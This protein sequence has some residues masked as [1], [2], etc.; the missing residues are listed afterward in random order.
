M[1]E[2]RDTRSAL[3]GSPR[4]LG[5]P[6]LLAYALPAIPLAALTLPL[7]VL[8]PTFYTETLG[9]P[10]ASVGFAL[11]VVRIFDAVNDPL[12]GWAADRFRPRFGRRRALFALSLP[13]TAI[14]AFM[15][16]WPPTDASIAW[17]VGWGLMLSLGY[18]AALIPFSAWGAELATDYHGRSRITGWREG[19]TLVGTLIAIALPFTIGF[20]KADGLHGLALLGIV[21]LLAL[22]LFGA[23]AIIATP[24]P[25]EHSKTRLN[26]ASGLTHLVRNKPF[27]RLIAAFF[28]NGLANGIP[29]TLFLYFVSARLGLPEARGPLLF[30]YFLCAVAGVPVATWA[31]RRVGKH[32]AWCYAMLAACLAFAPAPLLPEGSLIAFAAICVVTGVLLGFDLSL[33]PAI[34]ADVIDVDTAASGEQR[35]G[36]YFAAWSLS[37]KLSLAGGV[38]IIFPVL[39]GFGFDPGTASGAQT[40]L[41]A[42][43][44]AYA[45]VPI[46]AKLIAIALMW[47][48]PLDEAAQKR[49]RTSIEA[50]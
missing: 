24:E 33:P 29:A 31:A 36:I 38:G 10:L 27:L 5:W 15:L 37:T 13:L 16:F 14:S 18:T 44:V 42:L 47:N 23:F 22:P 46:C 39:A 49:L 20:D 32:R 6:R 28:L 43:A 50:G 8:V 3:P 21:I 40:G 19:F 4:T 7:Y 17:L 35:S 11:L 41:T 45:W 30:L 1:T 12:I 48:F 26:L 9:L 34:Q 25:V 2:S